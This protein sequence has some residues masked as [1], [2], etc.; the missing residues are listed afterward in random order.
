MPGGVQKLTVKM[1]WSQQMTGGEVA[2]VHCVSGR[3]VDADQPVLTVLSD[4]GRHVVRAVH[5]GRLVTLV[6]PGDAIVE[7]DALYVLHRERRAPPQRRPR[8]AEGAPLIERRRDRKAA[9]RLSYAPKDRTRFRAFADRWAWF[10]LALGAYALAAR[11]LIPQLEGLAGVEPL[12]WLGIAAGSSILGLFLFGGIA[13]R[14]SE[15]ARRLTWGLAMCWATLTTVTLVDLPDAPGRLPT[16]PEMDTTS[17]AA[18]FGLGDREPSA[19]RPDERIAALDLPATGVTETIADVP[20]VPEP[21]VAP[22]PEPQRTDPATFDPIPLEETDA[23]ARLETSPTHDTLRRALARRNTDVEVARLASLEMVSDIGPATGEFRDAAPS[24]V[25][26]R[27]AKVTSVSAPDSAVVLA[28]RR[29]ADTAALARAA[30]PAQSAATPVITTGWHQA[31]AEMPAPTD[32]S[33]PIAGASKAPARVASLDAPVISPAQIVPVSLPAVFAEPVVPFARATVAATLLAPAVN[34]VDVLEVSAPVTPDT[35]F[36]AIAPLKG[37]AD[38]APLPWFAPRFAK[39]SLLF[40]FVEDPR[41][42]GVPAIGD[43]YTADLP[44]E[45][46]LA[47]RSMKVVETRPMVQVTGWCVAASDTSGLKR[48]TTDPEAYRKVALSD[49]LRLVLVEAEIESDTIGLLADALPIFGT[50]DVGFFHNRRPMMGGYI[51]PQ[52][53]SQGEAWLKTRANN[54]IDPNFPEIDAGGSYYF[55]PDALVTALADHGCADPL[56]QGGAPVTALGRTVN[57]TITR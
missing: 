9:A 7:G 14:G 55:S 31:A 12:E 3:P 37:A 44:P 53:L 26:R 13:Q 47:V 41:T 15:W 36:A 32:L 1:P 24:P 11:L 18:A 6:S 8:G 46:A 25:K 52:L 40:Q 10:L 57:A 54:M 30:L 4:N 43:A 56:W 49:R 16:L 51:G 35:Q 39:V 50:G 19:E 48:I 45:V 42:G 33:L 20:P 2:E 29:A 34:A 23:L 21:L 27:V 22:A 38:A 28:D 5:A 17:L